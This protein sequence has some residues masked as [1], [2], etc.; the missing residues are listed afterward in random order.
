MTYV[1]PIAPPAVLPV[2]VTPAPAPTLS[3]ISAPYS[4]PK[5]GASVVIRVHNNPQVAPYVCTDNLCKWAWWLT[6]LQYPTLFRPEYNDFWH[7]YSI[8]Q[9]VEDERKTAIANG[10]SVPTAVLPSTAQTTLVAITKI[11][12]LSAPYSTTV[13]SYIK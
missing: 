9:T 12:T 11:P 5:C 1:S 6:E 4:C 2:V 13:K 7:N 3:P 8:R 10:C